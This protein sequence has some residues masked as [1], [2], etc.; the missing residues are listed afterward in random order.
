MKTKIKDP[1]HLIFFSTSK[2]RT[3]WTPVWVWI[4]SSEGWGEVFEDQNNNCPECNHSHVLV[5]TLCREREAGGQD[6]L[7]VQAA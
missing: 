6:A 2:G 1:E 5:E 3:I 7:L 4:W